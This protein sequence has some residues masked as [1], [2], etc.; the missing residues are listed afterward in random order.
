MEDET[1]RRMV[2]LMMVLSFLL[3]PL[4]AVHSPVTAE[5]TL[6]YASVSSIKLLLGDSVTLGST[7]KITVKDINS[8]TWS[9][10]M[11]QVS[12]PDGTKTFTLSDSDGDY[13]Y[14]PS[15][16]NVKLRF[17]LTVWNS[18]GTPTVFLT[19]S[20]PLVKYNTFTVNKGGSVSIP[21]GDVRLKLT[22]CSNTSA[23]FSVYRP[24]TS[25][26]Y[27]FTI[28]PGESWGVPYKVS[29]QY[30]YANFVYVS[31]N[32]S[33]TSGAKFTVYV[34]KVPF[35]SLAVEKAN[36]GSNTN[37]KPSTPT[38]STSAYYL[39][40]D[41][42]LYVGE[43]LPVKINNTNYYVKLVST[44]PNV[45]KVEV[46]KG[47]TNL[48][49]ALLEVGDEPKVIG[50][51]PLKLSVQKVEPGYDRAVIKV[52]A[53]EGAQVTPILRQA[54][55]QVSMTAFPTKLMLGDY[56]VVAINVKNNGKG[57][58]YD[59][60]VVAP[61]P[62]GFQ[63]V[64]KVQ[65]WNIKTLPA[66]SSMPALIYVLKPTKVGTFTIGRASVSFYDDKSL[67]TNQKRVVYS[68]VLKGISVYATPSVLVSAQ[69]Y[70]G[71]WANYIHTAVN[72]TV[73]LRFDVKVPA[74]ESNY[75]YIQNA[76]LHLVIGNSLDGPSTIHLGTMKGGS[77]KSVVVDMKV[78]KQNLTNIKG[79]LTYYDPLGNEHTLELGNL[80]TINSIPPKVIVKEVKVWP[81]P[82]E[83]P[84]YVNKTLS[85]MDNATPL[86]EELMNVSEYY[87]PP[88]KKSNPWKPL[89]V[90]FIILTV[91]LAI[92]A[93][94]YWDSAESCRKVLER[95]KAKRPGGLPKKEEGDSAK[96][97]V[98]GESGR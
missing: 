44:I 73:K 68:P 82:K 81:A 24:Y 15:P 46:L 23:S 20:S 34:P 42:Y 38:K 83:L 3:L 50:N 87:I 35:T 74:K 91:I 45:V 78:L 62:S 12:G 30:D 31:L 29:D 71:T 25:Q 55:I 36:S 58:A 28:K 94:R 80:V 65:S 59:L 67:E 1:M 13:A 86:A 11:I 85:S 7:Y 48:G 22:S 39:A 26:P 9:S 72:R 97:P 57:D 96:P 60:N 6:P 19:I 70:N 43:S 63:L 77:S 53:P 49:S 95:K 40:Y 69:A 51:A 27:Q 89:A 64:S 98:K 14:Y 84:A 52:Y 8:L 54:N 61:I 5:E 88:E 92:V 47:K 21:Y 56:L 76:T 2:A 75:E 90:L 37:T 79:T 17:S 32:E 93:Y 4:G 10:A 41:D 66:F 33:T 18:E 16:S